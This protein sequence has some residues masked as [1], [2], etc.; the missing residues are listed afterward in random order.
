MECQCLPRNAQTVYGP[1]GEE[2]QPYIIFQHMVCPH[3]EVTMCGHF[4][5]EHFL[6]S[7][8][9][10]TLRWYHVLGVL[11]MGGTSRFMFTH[12]WV[13]LQPLLQG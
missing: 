12:L 13:T 5:M 2:L 9:A 10:S 1:T 6:T 7:V 3:I 8:L 11:P 4:L